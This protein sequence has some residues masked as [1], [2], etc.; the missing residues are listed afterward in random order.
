MVGHRRLARLSLGRSAA[1]ALSQRDRAANAPMESI[2]KP[3]EAENIDYL[4]VGV[5]EGYRPEA[6][7]C[8]HRAFHPF[9]RVLPA[10]SHRL[11]VAPVCMDRS[12]RSPPLCASA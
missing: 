2:R 10:K 3:V 1:A 6:A 11:G 5:Q 4:P 7:V 12:E 9:K 8:L